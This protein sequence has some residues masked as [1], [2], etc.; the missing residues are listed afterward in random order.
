VVITTL[1]RTAFQPLCPLVTDG[2][3]HRGRRAKMSLQSGCQR[4]EGFGDSKVAHFSGSVRQGS[5]RSSSRHRPKPESYC[6]SIWRQPGI[7]EAL[8]VLSVCRGTRDHV[9]IYLGVKGNAQLSTWSAQSKAG[10]LCGSVSDYLRASSTTWLRSWPNA[11][12]IGGI[13]APTQR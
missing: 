7:A 11:V 6:T 10:L 12:M 5:L 9:F 2:T 13:A 1:C 8:R 4:G 3:G